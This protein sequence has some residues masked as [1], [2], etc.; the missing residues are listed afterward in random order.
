[1]DGI[2]DLTSYKRTLTIWDNLHKARS[3]RR[4]VSESRSER[5]I[6]QAS[7][8]AQELQARQG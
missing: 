8:N 2:V 3:V 4:E 1:M 7:K 6:K 5:G